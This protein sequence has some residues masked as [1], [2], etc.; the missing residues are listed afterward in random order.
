MKTNHFENITSPN[1]SKIKLIHQLYDSRGRK[2]HKL[3][4]AEG[5]REISIALKSNY[6]PH[7]IFFNNDFLDKNLSYLNNFNNIPCFNIENSLFS[8]ISYR[9]DT[10]G[11]IAIFSWKNHD[12]ES[13]K[14]NT[15]PLII[16]VESVEKP[17]NLG[18]ILR[19]ADA[20]NVDAVIVCNPVIDIYNPNVIRSSIGCIFSVTIGITDSYTSIEW[21][22][23]HNITIYAAALQKAKLY[24][25]VDFI[26]PSAI[27]FGTEA[28]GLS[29]IWLQNAN[30]IIN[31]PMLGKIDSL[32]VSNSVAIITFEALRQRNFKH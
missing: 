6:K 14:L 9:E 21:L 27:V 19:T 5:K 12:L 17:G 30:E 20:A 26:Q 28:T 1:N 10:E 25:Q 15:N 24:T 18:A 8:K 31:I 16:V 3:F 13:I 11:I 7:Y 23:K 2:K 32:N 29:D 22:K 4:I